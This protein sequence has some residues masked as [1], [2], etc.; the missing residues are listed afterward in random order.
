MLPPLALAQL[1]TLVIGASLLGRLLLD[2]S[3]SP[4]ASIEEDGDSVS[5]VLH[6]WDA[7]WA[8]RR[9]VRVRLDDVRSVCVEPFDRLPATGVPI[10]GTVLPGRLR[11]GTF[12]VRGEREFWAARRR[13]DLLR[14][15]LGAGARWDRLL[16]Q[17]SDPNATAIA[18]RRRAAP[19]LG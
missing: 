14:V 12:L 3:D 1:T 5:V 7:L 9:R 18:L 6:G 13:G 2:R 11:V 15:E 8:Q 4:D 19:A 17:V 10:W 16:V